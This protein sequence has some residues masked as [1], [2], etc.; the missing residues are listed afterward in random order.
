MLIRQSIAAKGSA[1]IVT[2]YDIDELDCGHPF[3]TRVGVRTDGVN[4]QA[5]A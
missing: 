5:P 2:P 4:Q 1:E 3:R